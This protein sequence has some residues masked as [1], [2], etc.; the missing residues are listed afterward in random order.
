MIGAG[1]IINPIIKVATTLAILAA[2]SI[3]IIKPIIETS[4]KASDKAREQGDRISRQAEERARQVD[5][6]V[7]RG[8]ALDAARSARIAGERGRAE[9]ILRCVQRAGDNPTRMDLCRAL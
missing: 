3:F 8:I 1:T 5:L 9:R 6:N 2:V 7:S 4:E